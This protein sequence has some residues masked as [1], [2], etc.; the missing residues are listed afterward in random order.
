MCSFNKLK[1][2]SQSLFSKQVLFFQLMPISII[3]LKILHACPQHVILIFIGDIH[4]DSVTVISLFT[5]D[6]FMY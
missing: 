1:H 6:H 2:S 3:T 4:V 5:G